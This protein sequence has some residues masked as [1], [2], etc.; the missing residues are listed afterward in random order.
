MTN[1]FSTAKYTEWKLLFFFW[2]ILNFFR[3]GLLF[4][5]NS[6][7]AFMVLIPVFAIIMNYLIFMNILFCKGLCINRELWHF[8]APSY[9]KFTDDSSICGFV[10]AASFISYLRKWN[11]SSFHSVPYVPVRDTPGAVIAHRYAYALPRWRTSQYRKT[12]YSPL[13][14]CGMIMVTPYL[15]VCHETGEFQEHSQCLFCGLAALSLFVSCCFHF[16]FFHFMGWYCGARVFGL[17]GC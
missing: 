16:F 4:K 5:L 14:I 3:S 10:L 9:F 8:K 1:M 13:S 6:K 15:M 11:N 17:I 2:N 12:C 7:L